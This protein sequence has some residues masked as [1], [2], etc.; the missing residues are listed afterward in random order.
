MTAL[1]PVNLSAME[2]IRDHPSVIVKD[3][4]RARRIADEGARAAFAVIT[5]R[6]SKQALGTLNGNSPSP[7]TWCGLWSHCFC[8]SCDVRAGPPVGLCMACDGDRMICEAMHGS[9]PQLGAITCGARP[10]HDGGFRLYTTDDGM[11]HRVV[12]PLYT[13]STQRG[14][15][16]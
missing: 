6:G 15:R 12:P 4:S 2:A 1:A 11:F 7:C 9:R 8:E 16:V 3:L 5:R 14:R 10:A 13:D